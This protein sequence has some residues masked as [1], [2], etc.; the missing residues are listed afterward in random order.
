[1]S[2]SDEIIVVSRSDESYAGGEPQRA[3]V[4]YTGPVPTPAL[5]NGLLQAI[6]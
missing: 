3:L 5:R 4:V 6:T 1:M 2:H